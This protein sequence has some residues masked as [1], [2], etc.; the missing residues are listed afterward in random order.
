V[1][2]IEHEIMAEVNK[3]WREKL[4]RD[5]EYYENAYKQKVKECEDLKR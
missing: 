2:E 4:Y 3:Q 5:M 1:N